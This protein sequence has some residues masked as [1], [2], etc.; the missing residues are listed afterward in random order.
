[1][2]DE[3]LHAPSP[4]SFAQGD[5]D[6]ACVAFAHRPQWPIR[7]HRSHLLRQGG[8]KRRSG[9]VFAR[10]AGQ[11]R[12][13]GEHPVQF[14]GKW[15]RFECCGGLALRFGDQGLRRMLEAHHIEVPV[16]PRGGGAS[17]DPNRPALLNG[18][19]DG[20]GQERRRQVMEHQDVV[21]RQGRASIKL[22]GPNHLGLLVNVGFG[23]APKGGKVG[24]GSRGDKE[25]FSAA[26]QDVDGGALPVVACGDFVAAPRR[27]GRNGRLQRHGARLLCIDLEGPSGAAEAVV[28]GPRFGAQRRASRTQTQ[29]HGDAFGATRLGRHLHGES[30]AEVGDLVETKLGNFEVG[31]E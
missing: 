27:R 7:A 4:Q 22:G 16:V 28:G 21:V 15:E 9:A 24:V 18:V 26:F 8:H 25:D 20:R 30:V 13:H 2:T 17:H 23:G 6:A 29:R 5:C 10:G 31:D 14:G 19:R 11:R 12:P 1:M 3:V